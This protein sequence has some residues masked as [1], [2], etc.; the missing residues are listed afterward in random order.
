[1]KKFS[2]L[3]GTA[4]LIL[5]FTASFAGAQGF[6]EKL[7]VGANVGPAEPWGDA[8]DTYGTGFMF[9]PFVQYDLSDMVANLKLELS[10]GFESHSEKTEGAEGSATVIPIL[11]NGVYNIAS[12]MDGK[13][14]ILGVGGFGINMHS[15]DSGVEGLTYDGQTVLGVNFGAGATYAINEKMSASLR[16]GYY[17]SFTSKLSGSINGTSFESTEDYSHSSTPALIGITYKL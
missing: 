10:F 16:F 7:S 2:L 11:V 12:L 5:I 3:I 9:Q 14:S 17:I 13:V 1:M 6:A 15:W 4:V 8:G